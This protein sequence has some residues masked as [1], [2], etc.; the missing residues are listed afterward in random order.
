MRTY[1]DDWQDSVCWHSIGEKKSWR[2]VKCKPL[3]I[4]VSKRYSALCILPT[5]WE[6]VAAVGGGGKVTF[7]V[8]GFKKERMRREWM[9]YKEAEKELTNH[10]FRHPCVRFMSLNCTHLASNLERV[11]S[12]L[13]EFSDLVRQDW[14]AK[15]FLSWRKRVESL[16]DSCREALISQTQWIVGLKIGCAAGTCDCCEGGQ[17]LLKLHCI[18]CCFPFFYPARPVLTH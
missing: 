15:K 8:D 10:F 14:K 12:V 3:I 11:W 18:F 13:S 17:C 5:E 6:K 16:A 7:D 2:K 1:L 9:N 4:G